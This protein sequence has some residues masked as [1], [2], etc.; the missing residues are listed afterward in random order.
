MKLMVSYAKVSKLQ[1]L[2]PNS[3]EKQRLINYFAALGSRQLERFE[4]SELKQHAASLNQAV[5]ERDG[6]IASLNQAVAERDRQIEDYRTSKSWRITKPMRVT[7]KCLRRL[8]P[9]QLNR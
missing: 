5:T 1:W 4:L 2:Q 6:Q 8:L 7:M 3:P 9:R